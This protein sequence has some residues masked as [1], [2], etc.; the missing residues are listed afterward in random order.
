MCVNK[1]EQLTQ[2][3]EFTSFYE[4]LKYLPIIWPTKSNIQK[5]F[6]YRNTYS[7]LELI[8]VDFGC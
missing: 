8:T 3:R 6:E 1:T 2:R 4:N 5:L 7:D